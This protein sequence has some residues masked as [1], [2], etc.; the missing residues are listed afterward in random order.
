MVFISKGEGEDKGSLY[1]L[2]GNKGTAARQGRGYCSI[3]KN[4]SGRGPWLHSDRAE[5]GGGEGGGE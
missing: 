2:R 5:E 1:L 3:S 4:K